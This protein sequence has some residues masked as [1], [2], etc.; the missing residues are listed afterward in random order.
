MRENGLVAKHHAIPLHA[1]H[2]S[3]LPTVWH[4]SL[5]LTHLLN[6]AI[7]YYI[8]QI[9]NGASEKITTH[10]YSLLSRCLQ[11]EAFWCSHKHTC[12]CTHTH[13]HTHTHTPH[14]VSLSWRETRGTH[15][16][17]LW[18][19]GGNQQEFSIRILQFLLSYTM[20]VIFSSGMFD[21]ECSLTLTH[22]HTHMH[23]HT[24]MLQLHTHILPH[25]LTRTTDW[26]VSVFDRNKRIWWCVCVWSLSLWQDLD[27]P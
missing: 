21:P 15:A 18:S 20:P 4:S 19:G 24:N 8:L 14:T 23:T 17:M 10:A 7:S 5:L 3:E 26:Q 22:P 11:P 12:T 16:G 9:K 2:S 6:E 1:E 13:A 25:Y 27:P